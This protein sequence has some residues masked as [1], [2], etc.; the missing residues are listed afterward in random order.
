MAAFWGKLHH[1]LTSLPHMPPL[2]HRELAVP[3]VQ[4]LPTLGRHG[5]NKEMA[6]W[7]WNPNPALPRIHTHTSY[8]PRR[9]SRVLWEPERGTPC[10]HVSAHSLIGHP[11]ASRA[12]ANMDTHQCCH[13]HSDH[14]CTP[15][16]TPPC[17]EFPSLVRTSS[18]SG[19]GR[20]ITQTL[21]PD[22]W[23]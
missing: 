8:V 21:A 17:A 2:L 18:G 4:T 3:R 1:S 9:R 15:P 20:A 7:L 19:A 14:L 16:P 11:H 10:A 6:I 5:G 12:H 23:V 22:C 13:T